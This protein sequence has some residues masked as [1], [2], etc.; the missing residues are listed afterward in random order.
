MVTPGLAVMKSLAV[1]LIVAPEPFTTLPG[2]ALL[3]VALFLAKRQRTKNS[4]RTQELVS[5]ESPTTP[6]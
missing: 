6:S 3:G 4:M 1:G 5:L 2:V